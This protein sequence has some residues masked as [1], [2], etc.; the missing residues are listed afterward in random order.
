[1]VSQLLKIGGAPVQISLG[2]R[3]HAEGPDG[4]PEWGLRTMLTLLFPK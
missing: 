2:G 3:Y 1:M 4:G